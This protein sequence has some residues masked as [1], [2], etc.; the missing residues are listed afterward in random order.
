MFCRWGRVASNP[1]TWSDP[2]GRILDRLPGAARRARK[3]RS[4]E[5]R[6]REALL[7]VAA[8]VSGANDLESVLELA[9]EEALRAIDAASL[10]ISRFRENLTRYRTLINVGDLSDWEERH[11]DDETYDVA[12][13]P[14]LLEMSRTANPYFNAVDDPDCDPAAREF[15]RSVGKSSDLGVAIVVEGEIWGGIWATTSSRDSF[16]AEDV[17]FLESIGGQIATAIARVELFSRVSRLAYE[18]PLTGLANRRALEE[19]LERALVRHAAGE[20]TVALMLC[21]ADRLKQINDVHGHAGGDR[22]LKNIAS[23]LVSAAATHRTAFVARIGGDEFCVL[24]ESLERIAEGTELDAIE[25]I[26]AAAQSDLAA[27]RPPLTL[28]CGGATATSR[29]ATSLK[30]LAAADTAQYVAKRRGGN[31]ICTAAQIAD[32]PN[33]FT[34]AP[35]RGGTPAE[36]IAKAMREI[37]RA[38]DDELAEAPALA[39]LECV[40][41]TLTEACDFASCAVSIAAHGS[42]HLRELSLGDNRVRRGAGVQVVRSWEEYEQY[43]LDEYPETGRIVA[44]GSGSFTARVGDESTDFAERNLLVKEGFEGVVAAAAGDDVGV[45][46]V[47]LL[48]DDPQTNLRA[49]EAALALAVAAAIP[50]PGHRRTARPDSADGRALSLTTALADQLAGATATHEVA[51]AVVREVQGAFDCTVVHL[52]SIEDELLELR[53]EK[54]VIETPPGWSQR[55]DAGLIGRALRERAPV[56]AGDVTREPQYRSTQ[57]TRDIRSEL[58]VPIYDGHEIWGAINLEDDKLGAFGT[59]DCRLIESVAAQVGGT[60][61]SIRLYKQLDRAYVGTAEALSAALEAKDSYTAEH[62]QSIADNAVAVGRLLGWRGEEIRMLRYAAAFHDIGKLA[63]SPGLLNKPGPLTEEEW[64][65]MTTHTLIGEKILSPIEF[66]APIRPLVRHAHE[67]WDGNGYPDKLSGEEIPLGARIL[68]ACDAYDAMTTDRSYRDA[69]PTEQARAELR[70]EAGKQ[71]DPVV[72]DA[73]LMVL[74]SADEESA[75]Y[76]THH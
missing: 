16:E 49:K 4:R 60:L 59:D 48:S 25:E 13:F 32:V 27:L 58:V 33:P 20:S 67:R 28:S 71:F 2:G 73:L 55:A 63:I 50:R 62:S 56:L 22:A 70:R 37:T 29:T 9:A 14:G 17:R 30:L 10:T 40:A 46:V 15:L 24:V 47:E 65:E 5:S 21:D 54:G 69:L 52:V 19:R 53:A 61:T 31:R 57:A 12:K 41:T 51:E 39:R 1:L 18:D 38:F 74:E 72:V 3:P 23:A 42:N 66:L 34:V 6:E 64:E 75:A 43:P 35:L 36:R 45:Y 11:P 7:R 26:A 76:S 68:F 44:A 8:A